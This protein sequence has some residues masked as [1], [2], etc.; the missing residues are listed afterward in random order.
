MDFGDVVVL[1]THFVRRAQLGCTVLPRKA[2]GG[3]VPHDAALMPDAAHASQYLDRHGVQHFIADHHPPHA[4][5][6]AANPM[7]PGGMGLER[8]LLSLFEGL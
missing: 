1:A 3:S 6:Q 8:L 5:G 7:N 4:C 2:I